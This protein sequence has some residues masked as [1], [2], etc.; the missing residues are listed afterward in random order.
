MIRFDRYQRLTFFKLSSWRK[1]GGLRGDGGDEGK[2]GY[3]FQAKHFVLGNGQISIL[4]EISFPE[5]TVF[6]FSTA[7]LKYFKTDRPKIKLFKGLLIPPEN[8]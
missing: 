6:Y 5:A 2:C 4:L 8:I 3:G 7:I 1:V